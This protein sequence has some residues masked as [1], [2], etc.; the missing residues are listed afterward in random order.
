MKLWKNRKGLEPLWSDTT[1]QDQ[2]GFWRNA[3]LLDAVWDRL[4]NYSMGGACPEEVLS[5]GMK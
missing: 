4:T 5:M 3:E 2:V 1:I